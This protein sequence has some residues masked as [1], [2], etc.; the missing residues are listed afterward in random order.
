[1]EKKQFVENE[2]TRMLTACNKNIEKAE[3]KSIG[4]DEFVVV[5]MVN[6]VSYKI[7]VTCDSLISLVADVV[8]YMRN[9]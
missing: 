3:Y 2:L 1:M 8:R 6:A 4:N 5:T 7:C 9:K